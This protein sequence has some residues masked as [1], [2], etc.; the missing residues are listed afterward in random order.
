MNYDEITIVVWKRVGCSGKVSH[1]GDILKN[2][3]V[4]WVWNYMEVNKCNFLEL[5]KKT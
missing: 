3:E 4:I 1:K 5:S 2:E